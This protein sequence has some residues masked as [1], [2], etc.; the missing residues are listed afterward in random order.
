MGNPYQNPDSAKKYSEYLNSPQGQ[1]YREIMASAIK[2]RLPGRDALILDAACGNG[3]LTAALSQTYANIR[4]CDASEFLI[5]E[6]GN[7]YPGLHFTVADLE[8]ELPY[9][10]DYFDFGLLCMAMH[11]IPHPALALQNLYQ[12][13][14][15]NGKIIITLPNPYYAF[16]VGAWKR[17]VLKFLFRQKPG[18]ALIQPYNLAKNL[19]TNKSISPSSAF[20]SL[21][22]LINNILAAG[23]NLTYFEDIKT[24]KDSGEFNLRYQLYRFPVL[25]LMEFEKPARKN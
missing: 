8:K 3:W 1:I 9:P 15:P 20:H 10:K 2:P 19:S 25:L 16:P 18:L 4:G 7:A 17:G 13:L 6:A 11:D 24:P 21:P 22:E 5:N 12:A 14:K 23:F